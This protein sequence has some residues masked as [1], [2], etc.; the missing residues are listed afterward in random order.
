MR[1]VG[2]CRRGA[3]IQ[4][5]RPD[6]V[7]RDTREIDGAAFAGSGGIARHAVFLDATYAHAHAARRHGDAVTDPNFMVEHG[8]GDDCAA[9]RDGER[10]V[11]RVAQLSSCSIPAAQVA[12][13]R[14]KHVTQMRNAFAG[15]GRRGN[16]L[17]GRQAGRCEQGAGGFDDRGDAPGVRRGRLW[18][19]WQCRRSR[20]AGR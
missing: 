8:A 19:R 6:F 1:S 4:S 18:S 7:E 2:A 13:R 14:G 11:N 9:P 5:P 15:K 16:H 20:P 12:R 17:N 10:P 3:T